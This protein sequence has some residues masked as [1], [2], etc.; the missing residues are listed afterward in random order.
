MDTCQKPW[1][2]FQDQTLRLPISAPPKTPKT[3]RKSSYDRADFD[4]R[5]WSS[6]LLHLEDEC[7]V[8]VL[9]KYPQ[10]PYQV[11]SGLFEVW[12]CQFEVWIEVC[13]YRLEDSARKSWW[14]IQSMAVWNERA[15]WHGSIWKES[16]FRGTCARKSWRPAWKVQEPNTRLWQMRNM[17]CTLRSEERR[18]SYTDPRLKDC[19]TCIKR[20]KAVFKC[21]RGI[22]VLRWNDRNDQSFLQAIR[23]KLETTCMKR[24]ASEGATLIYTRHFLTELGMID[25][26]HSKNADKVV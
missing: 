3:L 6:S 8:V 11:K 26:I 5:R 18:S 15:L 17:F 10:Q 13:D 25:V 1:T 21:E 12:S 9:Q 14:S 7:L 22:V 19:M 2:R 24:P 16:L 20:S 4:R 23:F